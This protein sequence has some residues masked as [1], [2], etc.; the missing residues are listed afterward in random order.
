MR[1]CHKILIEG[2][3]NFDKLIKF[4]HYLRI[5]IIG[6]IVAVFGVAMGG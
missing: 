1:T 5:E 2:Q 6:I 3:S 4:C